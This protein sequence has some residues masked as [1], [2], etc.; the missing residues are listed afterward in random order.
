MHFIDGVAV[1][2]IHHEK[3]EEGEQQPTQEPKAPAQAA[4]PKSTGKEATPT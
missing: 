1:G 2:S 4:A 3:A